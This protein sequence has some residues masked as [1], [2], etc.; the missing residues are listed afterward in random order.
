M[1][2]LGPFLLFLIFSYCHAFSQ[3]DH[4][5]SGRAIRFD[6][7]DDYVDLGNIYDDAKLPITISAWVFVEPS[8]QYI[9]PIFISQD[10]AP[11][12]NGFWL[13][14]SQTNLFF[15]YGDGRGENNSQFRRGKSVPI[16]NME[17]RWMHVCAVAKSSS[18]IQ[19]YVNG[20][21][22][23]GSSTG[24][25]NLPM[26][27][28][29][30]G[31]V[32]KIGYYKTNAVTHR[33]KGMIDEL[34]IWNRGLSESEVRETMCRSLAGNEAGL[35]GY[36]NFDETEGDDLIDSSPN[37]F[38]GKVN[39]TAARVFSGAPIGEVSSYLYTGSWSGKNLAL[40]DFSVTK[41]NGN[42]WGAHIYR[43]NHIPSQTDGLD[44]SGV[45]LPYYGVFLADNNTGNTFDFVYGSN[46]C[47]TYQRYDNSEPLWVQS[48]DFTGINTRAEIIRDFEQA[49]FDVDL[50]DDVQLCDAHN[51]LLSPGGS[52][53]GKTFLWN[54][55]ATTQEL[56]VTASGMYSLSVSE[57][58]QVDADTVMVS[59]GHRPPQFSL[60]DDEVLCSL[61]PRLL[62]PTLETGDYVFK[63]QDGSTNPT[64]EATTF[65]TYWLQ[66]ENACGLA[67]DTIS[68]TRK[69]FDTVLDVDLG[70]DVQL[71]DQNDYL[72][73]PGGTASGK[74]FL[75][76]TG[77]TTQEITV[78]ASGIYSVSVSEE[79]Q[80]DADTVTIS[81]Q[82]HP[83]VFSLGD[84]EALCSLE[85][86][87]LK[88]TLETGDYAFKWQ[89]GS[90][91]P[92]FEAT[93]FG[94]YWL[95]IQNACGLAAD[96]ITFTRKQ[97]DNIQ[98]YNFIS[99]DNEDDFNQYFI[100]DDRLVGSKLFVF[101]RWGKQVFA[102]MSYHNEWTGGDLPSGVYFYTI[103]NECTG[104]LK[105]TVTIMK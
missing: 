15:E 38:H 37:A 73:T 76:N 74:T 31:D 9:L 35:I 92:T 58:C 32:A 51:Y 63:W 66:I 84:D 33:F 10:N 98:T 78:T 62:K 104:A 11:L 95:Q 71:C 24:D 29:F 17:N 81:F 94:T 28:D 48:L 75:W 87:V 14:L 8:T 40:D 96:T 47:S 30:P 52:A 57:G 13:C 46:I 72:L 42:P 105:G 83:P 26:S 64:F 80:L 20:Q 7:V 5:G 59:F 89:D 27:S 85:P 67:G 43:V 12:Y 41:V 4:V 65:G 97:F 21:N 61:E 68:F 101:N 93:T 45:Q 49:K 25:S 36:W 39:G 3:T 69:Q 103:E 99:P 50:G 91:N 77:A 100:I 34:R 102:S 90:T 60:G 54:T 6:A 53:A 1:Y 18:D 55:G 56:S 44:A 2:K 22:V 86:R 70:D 88:P 16:A 19:L 79:C 82:N 23:G